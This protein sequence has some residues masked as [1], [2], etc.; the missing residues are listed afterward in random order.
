MIELAEA[1]ARALGATELALDTAQPAEH[2][3]Q[4]YQRLG[5]RFIEYAQWDVTNYRSVILSKR[6]VGEMDQASQD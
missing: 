3:C 5:F 6:L 2:L 1:E 4:W